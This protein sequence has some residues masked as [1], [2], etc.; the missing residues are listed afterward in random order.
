MIQIASMM[1]AAAAAHSLANQN[2]GT[3]ENANTSID[4]TAIKDDM[5]VQIQTSVIQMTIFC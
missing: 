3:A 2:T 1:K 4:I 5:R